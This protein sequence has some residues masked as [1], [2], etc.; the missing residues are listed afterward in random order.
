VGCKG[1]PQR[2]DGDFFNDALFLY[3]FHGSLSAVTIHMR[4]GTLD[5][6]GCAHG[7][8]V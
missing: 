4:D 3:G 5:A 2:V 1:V 7:I 6:L 8:G